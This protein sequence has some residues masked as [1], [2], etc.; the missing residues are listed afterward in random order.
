MKASTLCFRSAV[1]LAII[2]MS[3]G[4]AMA[5][6]NNHSPMPAHA[7]LNLLGW[8]SMFL[9]GMFYR[10]HPGLDASRFA[11]AQVGLW[12][13]GTVVLTT[14]VALIYL[15]HPE[16]EP[17]AGVGSFALLGAMLMF[18]YAVFRPETNRATVGS[19]AVPAE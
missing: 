15:G 3:A 2:G 12:V 16:F 10:A 5:I 7:H 17:L 8:V 11:L 9:I 1:C 14:G 13:V 18:A 19:N 4:I 6:S